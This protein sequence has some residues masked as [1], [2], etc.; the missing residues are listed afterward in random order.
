MWRWFEQE[1]VEC[2]YTGDFEVYDERCLDPQ[3]A[4]VDIYIAIK[5]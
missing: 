4:Q 5:A 2:T 3:N 1:E